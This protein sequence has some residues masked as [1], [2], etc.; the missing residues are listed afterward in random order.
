MHLRAASEPLGRTRE[1]LE[2]VT[3]QCNHCDSEIEVPAVDPVNCPVCGLDPDL[4]P[5]RYAFDDAPAFFMAGDPRRV[6]FE[7][8]EK[9]RVA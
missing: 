8:S 3:R 9:A 7:I 5:L 4:P 2:M 6:S 1:E